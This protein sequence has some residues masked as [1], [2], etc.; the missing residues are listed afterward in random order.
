MRGGQD[1]LGGPHFG[2]FLSGIVQVYTQTGQAVKED[3]RSVER[4]K[5]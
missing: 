1:D 4:I 3:G 2:R 5:S